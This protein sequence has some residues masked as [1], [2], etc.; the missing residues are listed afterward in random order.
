MYHI[1][2]RGI[3]RA[4]LFHDDKDREMYLF[5]L[6]LAKRRF[7]FNL[8]TFCL[9]PNHVHLQIEITTCF[10]PKI[11]QF[12]NSSYA[13]YFYEKHKYSGHVFDRRYSAFHVGTKSYELDL[14]R[15]I[16]LNPLRAGLTTKPEDY[17]WSSCQAYTSPSSGNL[18][19]TT[20]LLSYFKEPQR[21]NYF[22]FLM[23][24]THRSAFL[25]TK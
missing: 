24:P 17:R 5:M 9:M 13:T 25:K 18:V 7:R 22:R 19:H 14:S 1:T 15:Y 8:H 3:R 2:C 21:G 16:H 23:S 10:P 4:L 6:T 11:M 20:K 12:I